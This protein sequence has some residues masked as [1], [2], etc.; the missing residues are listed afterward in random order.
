[1]YPIEQGGPGTPGNR[2]I[3]HGW[4]G[5]AGGPKEDWGI[6]FN[7]NSGEP[8]PERITDKIFSFTEKIASISQADI[9]DVDLSKIGVNS[10]GDFEVESFSCLYGLASDEQ[11]SH[12]ERCGNSSCG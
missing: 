11:L 10:F 3:Q 6:K 5:G 7:Y 1:M 4:W 2:V 8:A 9:P 12:G